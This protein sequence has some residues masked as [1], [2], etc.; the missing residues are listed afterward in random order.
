MSTVVVTGGTGT[1]GREVV[2]GLQADGHDVVITSRKA[3][4][5]VRDRVRTVRVDYHSP[6][7]LRA[8]FEGADTVVH[9]ATRLAGQQGGDVDLGGR[10][11][12]AARGAGCGH[13]VYISIVGV[14]RI[15]LRYYQAKLET[16]RLVEDCGLPWTILRATQF[17]ELVVRLLNGL[18][19]PPL[20]LI[21]DIAMQP[22]AA[23]EAGARLAE[24]AAA[25][26]AGRV[27]DL[28]GPEIVAAPRLARWYLEATGRRRRI[29]PIRLFGS[30]YEAYRAGHHLTPANA[31]GTI[32]FQDY[33]DARVRPLR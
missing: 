4:P 8:A 22:I 6:V 29:R 1:L 18:T 26:P 24:L 2:R 3:P 19:R 10:V 5:S 20:A 13:L 17:H 15:P 28:G 9:C 7:A 14:D 31:A 23:A 21:P 32:T 30:V 11:F 33:L 25:R 12:D 16:E 27:P